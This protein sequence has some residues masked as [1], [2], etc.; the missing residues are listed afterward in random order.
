MAN[1]VTTEFV[2][3]ATYVALIL[4]AGVNYETVLTVLFV[5]GI[6]FPIAYYHHSWS[7]W[8]GFDY[9]LESLPKASQIR[10]QS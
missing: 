2:I 6:L 9:L 8:L 1:V 4:I 10:G 3:L 7:F 5:I